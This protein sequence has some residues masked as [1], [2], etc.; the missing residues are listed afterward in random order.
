M[1]IRSGE[2]RL[3]GWSRNLLYSWFITLPRSI[4]MPAAFVRRWDNADVIHLKQNVKF[5][6]RQISLIIAIGCVA[7]ALLGRW[8]ARAVAQRKIVFELLC[9]GH[10]VQY[11]HEIYWEGDEI[12][13]SNPFASF[14]I[15]QNASGLQGLILR[16]LGRDYSSNVSVILLVA[17]A[18]DNELQLV[19]GLKGLRHV[20]TSFDS[21][22]LDKDAWLEKFPNLTFSDKIN[23]G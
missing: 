18:P 19:S 15:P 5:S 20:W 23:D 10:Q 14:Q 6:L 4:V 17:E 9:S 12:V 8:N 1:L 3:V 2:A 11:S 16:N 13:F 21:E 22:L 7:L